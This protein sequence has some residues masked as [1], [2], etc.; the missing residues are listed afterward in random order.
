M[1]SRSAVEMLPEEVKADLDTK[2]LSSGFSG[3]TGLAEWLREKGYEISRSSLHRYG[4]KFEARLGALKVAT[5]QA[6]AIAEAVGDD[7]NMLGEALVALCQ[8]KAF[9]VLVNFEA[10]EVENLSLPQ[11]SRAISDLNRAAVQQKKFVQEARERLDAKFAELEKQSEGA[12][13]TL[14]PETLKRIREEIYGV[15]T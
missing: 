1:P 7:Q 13:R 11:L 14:D 8:Q 3:Y 15:F 2:L 9:D 5:E 10:E 4:S 12:K 6:K